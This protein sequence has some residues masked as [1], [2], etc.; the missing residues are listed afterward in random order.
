M[1]V[2]AMNNLS[3]LTPIQLGEAYQAANYL[4]ELKDAL[5]AELVT[6]LGALSADLAAEIEDRTPVDLGGRR[7]AEVS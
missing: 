6:K 5:D 3:R 4:C 7:A 2:D 1:E